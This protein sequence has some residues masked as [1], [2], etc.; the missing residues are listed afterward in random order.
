[1][2][3]INSVCVFCGSRPGENPL[4]AELAFEFGALLASE[5]VRLVYGGGTTGLMGKVAEGA[6]SKGG[7]VT[8][9]IP[10]F[11]M[12]KERLGHSLS[13]LDEVIVTENMHE[14]KML[15]FEKSD[16]FVALPGGIGTLEELVEQ[17]TW[18]QLRQH[19][20]PVLIAD[21]DGFWAPLVELIEH[22]TEE[23]F[24]GEPYPLN[25]YRAET[26]AEILPLLRG[27]TPREILVEEDIV[28]TRM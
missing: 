19:D 10:D 7:D 26:A 4:Y 12:T 22:M 11:L 3:E 27:H 16:A 15:M 13:T 5:N 28:R 20:K 9:I 14:R 8:G 21:F 6:L 18:A 17:M 1:M 2:T 25:Y 24:V 23:N